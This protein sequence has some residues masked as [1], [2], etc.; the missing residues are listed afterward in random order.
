MEMLMNN[1]NVRTITEGQ[2]FEL[3]AMMVKATPKLSDMSFETAEQWIGGQHG[4]IEALRGVL[5]P[6]PPAENEIQPPNFT[7]AYHSLGLDQQYADF[8]TSN[9]L[10]F[11]DGHWNI[12]ALKGV[13]C[14][15]VVETFRELGVNVQTCCGDLDA[16]TPV[17]DRDPDNGSYWISC[18]ATVEADEE[19][20][21]LSANVLKERNIQ[22]LTLLERLLL[23]LAYYL[24]ANN[25]LDIKNTTYCIGSR[26]L[27]GDVPSV[28]WGSGAREI[29]VGWCNPDGR[30]GNLRARAAVSL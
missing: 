1:G 17:N 29:Q 8:L 9:P 13:T 6:S 22:G 18:K 26:Y 14:D 5:I 24:T 16:N 25:H 15:K 11:V 4:F 21:N 12:P 28:G 19:L 30:F 20:K 23:G 3:A 7:L 27:D 2:K 10:P